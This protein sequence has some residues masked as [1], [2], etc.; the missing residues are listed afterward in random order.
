MYNRQD[1]QDWASRVPDVSNRTPYEDY[2]WGPGE[3]VLPEFRKPG[4]H[5][6]RGELRRLAR[7]RLANREPVAAPEYR[8]ARGR[9]LTSRRGYGHP[10]MDYE[11]PADEFGGIGPRG[12]HRS[13][14][15]ILANILERLTRHGWIDAREIVVDVNDGEVTLRGIVDNREQKHM[16]EDIAESVSGVIQVNDDI[17]VREMLARRSLENA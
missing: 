4:V 2:G 5:L 12:Y 3:S 9:F 14:D 10:L 6:T 15:R 13:D 11:G 1:D 16:A 17:K 8:T 7:E